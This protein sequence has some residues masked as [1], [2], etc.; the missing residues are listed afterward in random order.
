MAGDVAPEKAR[1]RLI[2]LSAEMHLEY[3]I[4]LEHE[5]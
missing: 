4:C 3:G 1:R 5:I 2:M